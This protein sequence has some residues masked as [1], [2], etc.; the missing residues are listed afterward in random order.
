MAK[1]VGLT[2]V[3]GAYHNGRYCP[4]WNTVKLSDGTQFTVPD[5]APGMNGVLD[6]ADQRG[7]DSTRYRQRLDTWVKTGTM[8]DA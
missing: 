8:P 7:H 5:S 4:G 2:M 3:G 1:V 6:F